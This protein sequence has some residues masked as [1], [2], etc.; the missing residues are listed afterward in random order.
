M[1]TVVWTT[2]LGLPIVQPYRKIIRKQIKTAIQSV[3]ISDPNANAE[4]NGVKQASAFPPNFIHSLDATHMML[5]ALECRNR[6]LTFASVHDS[7]WT[8][9][10]D[11]DKMSEIIRETF[12]ALHS[13][14]ILGKLDAEFRERYKSHKVPLD[15][16]GG[17]KGTLVKGLHAA[18]SN[19]LEIQ[20]EADE[21]A[22]TKN[23]RFEQDVSEPSLSAADIMDGKNTDDP[24]LDLLAALEATD[25]E[26]GEMD[27]VDTRLMAGKF[28]N[29]TD[30]LPPVP[31]K[32]NFKV[33]A[34]KGS[35]Y[36]FS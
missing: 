7:Y 19:I 13:S 2:P 34:I 36:F 23:V 6:E 31:A 25:E 20:K 30:L 35:Q 29:L 1:T 15:G 18:G 3:Y 24:D 14:D 33:E 5:T 28:V 11:I 22:L 26:D 4:V 8:H 10:C 16:I 27:D 12:I 32:G 17:R 21:L 9:A